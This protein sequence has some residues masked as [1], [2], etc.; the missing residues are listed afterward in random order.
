MKFHWK[1]QLANWHHIFTDVFTNAVTLKSHSLTIPDELLSRLS[2]NGK[3]QIVGYLTIQVLLLFY[4]V[5]TVDCIGAVP[6]FSMC[7]G[8]SE[9]YQRPIKI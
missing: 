3:Q 6:K 2:R 9:F 7:E 5:H 1:I 4:Y 8:Y